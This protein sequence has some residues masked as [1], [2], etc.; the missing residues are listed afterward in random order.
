MVG[1][2][3]TVTLGPGDVVTLVV[4]E[5][6]KP[7][8]DVPVVLAIALDPSTAG[9]AYPAYSLELKYSVHDGFTYTAGTIWPGITLYGK[10]GDLMQLSVDVVGFVQAQIS[11]DG[12]TL[13]TPFFYYPT[14]IDAPLYAH[15]ATTTNGPSGGVTALL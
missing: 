13:W 15:L 3:S 4:G 1:G 2:V 11:Q 8:V 10:P 12:G 7:D 6:T 14:P 5:I 9:V